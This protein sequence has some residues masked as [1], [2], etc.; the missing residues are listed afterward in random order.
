VVRPLLA[1]S[2]A[3]EKRSTIVAWW[4]T[5]RFIAGRFFQYD[6]GPRPHHYA[7][8]TAWRRLRDWQAAKGTNMGAVDGGA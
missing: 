5:N 6:E 3:Y 7:V 1:R 8:V 2:V 4:R